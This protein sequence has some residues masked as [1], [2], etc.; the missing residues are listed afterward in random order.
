MEAIKFKF[1][2]TG[3]RKTLLYM[4][5]FTKTV[6]HLRSKSYYFKHITVISVY[7]QFNTCMFV[8]HKQDSNTL[9]CFCHKCHSS[10]PPCCCPRAFR[11]TRVMKPLKP[12]GTGNYSF[13]G[14]SSGALWENSGNSGNNSW[15]RPHSRP[16]S[17]R[18]TRPVGHGNEFP[19]RL[20]E[21]LPQH[22][23]MSAV[24]SLY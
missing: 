23:F 18:R 5:N 16:Q 24:I 6:L 4:E 1:K 17:S 8:F 12:L 9:N 20:C 11:W 10:Y 15:R 22:G 21:P 3:I 14:E 2:S 7:L 13:S 19:R